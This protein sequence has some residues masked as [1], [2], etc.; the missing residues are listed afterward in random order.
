MSFLSY[1]TNI[2]TGRCV[3]SE[4]ANILAKRY[5]VSMAQ[6]IGGNLAANIRQLREMRGMTQDQMSRI[7]A[8]PRP[9]WA[10][11]ESGGSNPTLSV[12]VKVANAL[13]VPVEE[14]IGPPRAVVK[15]YRAETLPVTSRGKVRLRKLLPDV[16]AGMEIDRM[17]FPPGAYMAGVPHTPGTREYLTCESGTV[18]LTVAGE[19][20]DLKPG[21]VLVFRG[22]QKHGYRNA[23]SETAIAYSVVALAPVAD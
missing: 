7:S 5:R 15:L 23:G 18:Q 21:D 11:L 12:L 17:E 14:L 22:D 13:R 20:W 4:I 1:G 2:K 6:S 16:I 10:N 3:F 8:I 19:S 9:T